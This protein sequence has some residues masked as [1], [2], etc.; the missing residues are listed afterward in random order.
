MNS[1]RIRSFLLIL[2]CAALGTTDLT[3]QVLT[4]LDVLV[5]QKF[6][7]LKGKKI[8]LIT[9]HTGLSREGKRNLDLMLNAGVSVKTLFSPEHG[10]LGA[11][12]QPNVSDSKDAKT[13]LP[14]YSLHTGG[15]YK[16]T[17]EMLEGIDAFVYDIQDVGA[18]FYTYS[19]TMLYGME[20]AAQS[21]IP[22]YVLDRP[23]PIT[24]EHVEGPVIDPDLESFVGCAPIPIRHG[25]T[26]GELALYVNGERRVGADLR[27]IEMRGWRRGDWWDATGLTWL[28]PS[29]NMNSLPAAT[30]YTGTCLLESSRN[31][32][33]GRGT[34]VAYEQ[35]GADWVEGPKLAAF[36]NAR[37]IPGVRAYPTRFRP[38]RYRFENQ[39][40]E[41]VRFVI[42]DRDAL[43]AIRLGLEMIYAV[44][45][46]YPGKI[47]VAV[48]RRLIG[49]KAVIAALEARK[50]P[51]EIEESFRADLQKFLQTRQKYLL[52][53]R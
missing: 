43:N 2:I 11:E 13:G 51:K 33:V 1:A 18:R 31:F 7:P 38:S 12:D 45:T 22:F 15:R 34:R 41:G 20:V 6:A 39:W 23:N 46:L 8:G 53:S 19:C 24:G 16:I 27:V 36:L 4:G 9:N 14:I 21:R 32:S 37:S 10:F 5:E 30:L 35:I 26:F 17:P 25:L 40:V 44:Q 28:D 42:T 3:A 50:D 29:P 49:S 47:D 52:Y 48:N